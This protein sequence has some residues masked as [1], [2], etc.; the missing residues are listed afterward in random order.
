MRL[1]WE[2]ARTSLDDLQTRDGN[3]ELAA[4]IPH[5]SHLSENLFADVPRKDQYEIRTGLAQ[6]VRMVDGDV[7]PRQVMSLLV[8][9]DVHRIIEEVRSNSAIVEE[10]E[11]GEVF[12][13]DSIELIPFDQAH[14]M[15]KLERNDTLW[16]EQNGYS[17]NEIV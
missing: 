7:R 6:F 16:F 2:L 13:I 11:V 9:A 12:V 4:P 14:Q 17:G 3:H 15:R 10:R 8:R 1:R 5:A